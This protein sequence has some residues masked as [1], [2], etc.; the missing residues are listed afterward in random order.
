MKRILTFC[1]CISLILAGLV[2]C[3]N[4]K[5][6]EVEPKQ[7]LFSE[8]NTSY[9][10]HNLSFAVEDSVLTVSGKI[11]ESAYQYLIVK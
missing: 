3:Q 10:E 11:K 4:K 2:G 8:L 1:L 9:G 5:A 6:E 7:P